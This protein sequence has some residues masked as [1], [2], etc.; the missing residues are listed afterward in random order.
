MADND[1]DRYTRGWSP[2][3]EI[4]F[5]T[6]EDGTRLRTLKTGK[7]P[8]LVL[9]HTLRTQLDYYQRLIPLLED[10]FTIYALDFPALGWSDIKPGART[11]A[12]ADTGHFFALERPDEVA[13][14]VMDRGLAG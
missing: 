7:G 6:L 11:I 3:G 13:G 2:D 4:A 5:V 1:T 14:L 8:V 12:L 10:R 9:L